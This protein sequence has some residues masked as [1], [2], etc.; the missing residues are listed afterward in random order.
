MSAPRIT[1]D[2]AALAAFAAAGRP[3]RVQEAAAF[4]HGAGY[5]R[6]L[7]GVLTDEEIAVLLPIATRLAGAPQAT[8]NRIRMAVELVA[9]ALEAGSQA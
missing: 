7:L 5:G 9:G 3:S 6:Q 1:I 4:V 2:P 8:R